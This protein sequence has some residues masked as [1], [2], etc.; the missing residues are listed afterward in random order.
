MTIHSV[1]ARLGAPKRKVKARHRLGVLALGA[2]IGGV[3]GPA[4]A[5]APAQK[6]CGL[7]CQHRSGCA[8]KPTE[9]R[10][11]RRRPSRR[12]RLRPRRWRCSA[13]PRRVRR[14]LHR[15]H[16]GGHRRSGR[17]QAE[18][19]RGVDAANGV[20]PLDAIASPRLE[21]RTL[22]LTRGELTV[23]QDLIID[24]NWRRR[25]R[26]HHRCRSREPRPEHYRHRH[27]LIARRI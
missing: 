4:A 5:A 14:D 27:R 21:G 2:L 7:A 13:T 17:R 19:A 16:G 12:R 3:P 6:R 8:A 11:P 22:V 9:R 10:R 25:R 24:G 26:D 1:G 23:S 15:D 18:L 20:A